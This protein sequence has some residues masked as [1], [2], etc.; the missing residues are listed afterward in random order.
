MLR[1]IGIGDNVVDRYLDLKM[2]FPGGNALNFSA[3]AKRYG[4]DSAYLGIVGNDDA[5]R[6]IK[7]ALKKENVD[8]S[9]LQTAAG[10][11]AFTDIE[12]EN[13]DRVFKNFDLSIYGKLNLTDA[14][15]SYIGTF[16]LIHT[17]VYSKITRYLPQFRRAGARVSFDFSD[18]W[19]EELIQEIIPQIDY[20]FMS[21]S[22]HSH[23]EIT[24]MLKKLVSGGAELALVTMGSDGA[25][26][27][28]GQ[29]FYHQ[30]VVPVEVVDTLGAGDAFITMFLLNY[31]ISKDIPYSLKLA[32][33][34]AA[35]SC[36]H[37]GAFGHGTAIQSEEE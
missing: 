20:A 1:V 28:D 25:M 6:L 22:G 8:I 30:E 13:G 33:A 3:L 19:D 31:L 15:F 27:Y 14:D 35:E 10:S 34:A 5:G 32:A 29:Q 12:L 26:L 9:R 4:F 7:A 18:K 16:D 11:T 36:T 21:G 37:Y 2:M 17:S 23:E 24:Q